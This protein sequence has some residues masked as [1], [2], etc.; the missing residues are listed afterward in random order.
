MMKR[1]VL[2]ALLAAALGLLLGQFAMTQ[3]AAPKVR[4]LILS[5]AN[6]HDWK[7]TTPYLKEMLEQTGRFQVEVTDTPA[8]CGPETLAKYDVVLDNYN[9]PRWGPKMERA[10]LDFVRGGKGLVVIHAANNPFADWPEFAVLIGGRWVDGVSG[11]GAQHRFMVNIRDRNHPITAGMPDFLNAE[12][13]FYHR[14]QVEPDVRLLASGFS[15]TEQGGTGQ[16]E[17]VAW[18]VDYGKGRVFHIVLGHGVDA[19]RGAGFVALTERGTDWAAT[20]AVTV[21]LDE[22][23]MLEET[24]PVGD[25]EARYLAESRLIEIGAPAVRPL[26]GLLG[27]EDATLVDT[28]K[29]VLRWIAQRWADSA[30]QQPAISAALLEFAR[31]A[32][33]VAVREFAINLLGLA[34]TREAVPTLAG[35]LDDEALREAARGALAQIPGPQAEAALIKALR[36]GPAEFRALVAADLGRRGDPT[37]VPALCRAA[38]DAAEA[39]SLAAIAALGRIGDPGASETL[40]GFLSGASPSA[41]AAAVDAIVR[42]GDGYAARGQPDAAVNL[43]GSMLPYAQQAGVPQQLAALTGLMRMA[44]ASALDQVLP[45]LNAPDER[46]CVMA[47]ATVGAIPTPEAAKALIDAFD[48]APFN[49]Q[50]TIAFVLGRRGD[51]AA[52][53]V[54][55]KAAQSED[56]GV[57]LAAVRGLGRVGQA[58]SIPILKAAME[59][60]PDLVRDAAVRSY[61]GIADACAA[62][63]ESAPALAIYREVLAMDTDDPN[64]IAALEGV[65]K[66]QSPE[67]VSEVEAVIAGGEEELRGPALSAYVAIADGLVAAGKKDEATAIYM[68]ALELLPATEGAVGVARKLQE[69]GV[70]VDIGALQGF[71]TDW[72]VVGPFPSP[73]KSAWDR[74]FFPEQEID[75]TKEYQ[76]EERKMSWRQ[77]HTDDLQGVVN[78]IPLF[79]PHDDQAAYAYAEVT[80]PEAQDVLV[81]I[82]SDDGVQCWLNGAL[83]DANNADRG[84]VVDQDVAQASLLAGK[85]ALLLKILNGS[86]DW[87]FVLRITDRDNKPLRLETAQ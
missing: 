4:V 51:A 9:G 50:A 83:I 61:L 19:M 75:L 10:L 32:Q 54:L 17:P 41:Q 49:V 45:F 28:A 8:E 70:A 80:A 29:R 7:T 53:P 56:E 58:S 85:N 84:V 13:E 42:I 5:G 62:R 3:S 77:F 87:G 30:E 38:K 31:P 18:T 81:K 63:G 27:S 22:I 34:G 59:K 74:V 35:F 12:D 47:V 11:H 68:K 72:W 86:G 21:P 73:D 1:I 37:A 33:A 39:V 71:I 24:L 46:V 40:Y 25:E 60:G 6:N 52:A 82:G 79:D 23:G 16:V 14:I 43:Y 20:G 48:N 36:S 64:K 57:R 44:N 2:V 78:L 65:A 76:V 15:A 55:E 69:L 67:A 66:L 26:F